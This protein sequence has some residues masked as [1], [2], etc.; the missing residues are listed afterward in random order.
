M[1]LVFNICVKQVISRCLM[2][3]RNDLRFGFL[4]SPNA[5]QQK[6]S[7]SNVNGKKSGCAYFSALWVALVAKTRR[8]YC[9]TVPC[10]SCQYSMGKLSLF[11]V[12][13]VTVPC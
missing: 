6:I 8:E 2:P 12:D 9:V 11:R 3:T 4:V 13:V 10:E 7:C 1:H 5:R